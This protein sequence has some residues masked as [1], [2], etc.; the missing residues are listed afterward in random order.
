MQQIHDTV[1]LQALV[2]AGLFE[3][4][5]VAGVGCAGGVRWRSRSLRR[6][7]WR[8]QNDNGKKSRKQLA[9]KGHSFPRTQT[10][11][12]SAASSCRFKILEE[13]PTETAYPV[14]EGLSLKRSFTPG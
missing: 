13:R 11:M 9:A 14:S 4:A 12:L 8:G 10:R 5:E 2:A 3:D 7:I 6:K 1:D